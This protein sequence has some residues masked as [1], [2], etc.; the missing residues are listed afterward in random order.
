M[1]GIKIVIDTLGSFL[2]EENVLG[3]QRCFVEIPENMAK[4]QEFLD[5]HTEISIEQGGTDTVDI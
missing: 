3:Y 5:S 1:I 4:F 2:Y